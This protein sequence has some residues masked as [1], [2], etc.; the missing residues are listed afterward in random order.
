MSNKP[1]ARQRSAPKSAQRSAPKSAQR[2]APKSAQRGKPQQQQRHKAQ[3][4][5]NTILVISAVVVVLI[6]GVIAAITA[7]GSSSSK[8]LAVPTGTEA[9]AIVT[10]VTTVPS[11]VID[12]VGF[13]T[14]AAAPKALN[15]DALTDN[16]KPALLYVGAE[17]CPFCAGERWAMVNALSRFGT[18]DKLS[19]THSSTS[20]VY[21]DTQT[22]SFYGST[23]TSDYISFTGVETATNQ[24]TGN[25]GYKELEKLTA[26]QQSVFQTAA[27]GGGFPFLDIGG[28]YL[29]A[30]ASYDVSVLQGKTA[31]Q[32]GDALSVASTSISQGIL[33]TANTLAAAI[34]TLT[35]DKPAT[36]CNAAG[37][38]AITQLPPISS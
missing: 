35:G 3:S 24:S 8:S 34:C 6:G 7:G 18:F 17:Y 26:E 9:A 28:R 1:S 4:K 11:S 27:P 2:S 5:R 13:G 16:G 19:F 15:G 12:A 32:I 31:G 38:K 22:F 10:K 25:G 36:V 29:V 21:P 20:D 33:G 23:Y 14:V 30:G 37:V